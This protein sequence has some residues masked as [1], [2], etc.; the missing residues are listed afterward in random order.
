MPRITGQVK[1]INMQ[2]RKINQQL[3]VEIDKVHRLISIRLLGWMWSCISWLQRSVLIYRKKKQPFIIM[4]GD[5][6]IRSLQSTIKSYCIY[7]T[8]GRRMHWLNLPLFLLFFFLL[9][10][11]QIELLVSMSCTKPDLR[12]N[13]QISHT[14]P[15]AKHLAFPLAVCVCYVM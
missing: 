1:V 4:P 13:C 5:L 10:L 9:S 12:Y 15:R 14:P 2:R 6:W 8:Y 3:Y 7:M 11:L